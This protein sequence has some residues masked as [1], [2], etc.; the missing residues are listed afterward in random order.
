[1]LI[2]LGS[3]RLYKMYKKPQALMYTHSHAQR[4]P[5]DFKL[6][7]SVGLIH[8][9][10][11][12]GALLLTVLAT[13]KSTTGGIV[14]LIIFGIGSIV[15]M[16]LAA[17]IFSVPFSGKVLRSRFVRWVLILLSSVLCIGLGIDVVY[18]NIFR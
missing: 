1:M 15:G 17:G 13:I 8:G 7:Y 12:S 9:L 2:A 18:E 5:Q 11:G 10:A 16:M 3:I 14:Y 4:L 6:A